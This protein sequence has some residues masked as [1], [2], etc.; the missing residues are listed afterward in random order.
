MTQFVSVESHES[1]DLK[2]SDFKTLMD[3]VEEERL[4]LVRTGL[5][6]PRE[7]LA[8]KEEL[9]KWVRH[10]AHGPLARP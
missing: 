2:A 10:W 3:A 4:A 6:V 7:L 1:I 5:P 9:R 8:K